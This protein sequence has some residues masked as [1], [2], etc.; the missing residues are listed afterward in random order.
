MEII[1]N[2]KYIK[3][4]FFD[5][6][7]KNK[8]I[9]LPRYIKSYYFSFSQ[10]E[11]LISNSK[12]NQSQEIGNNIEEISDLNDKNIINIESGGLHSLAMSYDGKI[13][14][15]GSNIYGQLGLDEQEENFEIKND[16]K[17]II[18]NPIL[19][20]N[21]QNIKI[22]IISCGEFHS[23]ALSENGDIFSWGG[24]SY[25][26]LGHSFID[27]MPKNDNNK[28][29]L[30]TPNIIESIRDIKMIDISCGKY[31]NI[32]IDN[33]GNIYSWGNGS[34]GQ[35]G[36]NNIYSL[37]KNDDGFYYQPIP[38][39]LKELKDNNIYIMKAA[40]GN[41]HSLILSTEGKIYSFGANNYGQLSLTNNDN[42][43]LY[44]NIPFIDTPTRV[45]GIIKDKIITYIS[46]GNH[47]CMVID[48]NNNLYRWGLCKEKNIESNINNNYNINNE[49]KYI[50]SPEIINTGIYG[51][52][53]KV[54]CGNFYWVALNK[55]D[56]PFSLTIKND[57]TIFDNEENN[58]I[59]T[60]KIFSNLIGYNITNISFGNDFCIISTYI[61]NNISLKQNIYYYFKESLY[62]DITIIY[63]DYKIKCH[64]YILIISSEYFSKNI[65]NET[66][67]III[68]IKELNVEYYIF[69]TIIQYLYLKINT[70]IFQYE[71][72]YELINYSKVIKYLGI[73]ELIDPIQKII[74][75]TI[76][77][78]NYINLKTLNLL[79][80]KN[81]ND[82]NDENTDIIKQRTLIGLDGNIYFL[83][84]DNM[85]KNIKENSI[86]INKNIMI[87]N[88]GDYNYEKE[89][90][91][92][93]VIDN[94]LDKYDKEE[95]NELLLSSQ[96]HKKISKKQKFGKNNILNN[97]LN[98]IS[99]EKLIKN[100]IIITSK[101]NYSYQYIQ[102]I[103]NNNKN[104]NDLI[105]NVNN[106]K[107]HMNKLL[108]ISS[109]EFFNSILNNNN[110]NEKNEINLDNYSPFNIFIVNIFLNLYE[111]YSFSFDF[112]L[113]LLSSLYL[114]KFRNE[115]KMYIEEELKK[116]INIKNV[117]TI[118]NIAKD[119]FSEKLKKFCLFYIKENYERIYKTKEF[120]NLKN[121]TVLE[122]N[123]FCQ[124]KNSK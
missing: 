102:Y 97:L 70:F 32:S 71:N 22:K 112:L 88:C 105:I 4:S 21:L 75:K 36:I 90:A 119:T 85:L 86:K 35:L 8:E 50:N 89:N 69:L 92:I 17:Q 33:N 13:Y 103:N 60:S 122:I 19:L 51:K 30:P 62:T 54:W 27:I 121:E 77:S 40:C 16:N 114:F 2:K 38:Y 53:E 31:H 28:P 25:G 76:E 48:N 43:K 120:E 73:N 58:N 80:S 10:L 115:F 26:Q 93:D 124:I 65:L 68:N 44:N 83:L 81:V 39:K 1:N 3:T 9:N 20:K 55:D 99:E 74:G 117:C 95:S 24:C 101:Y 57:I 7:Y 29:Y 104:I 37:S 108:L 111:Y 46:C 107:F 12:N 96:I 123:N 109:S 98:N 113:E 63:K 47:F 118:F 79:N 14:A 87:N 106:Y 66:K 56:I 59:F 41:D 67:E 15:W 45:E 72:I 61:K 64:K 78:Q 18:K 49:C 6:I 23:L 110:E 91:Q 34:Y 11:Q 94:Y 84:N 42:I 5:K 116:Y 100:N 82:N 52:V